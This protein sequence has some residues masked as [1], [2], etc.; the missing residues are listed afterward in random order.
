MTGTIRGGMYYVPQDIVDFGQE[1]ID[2]TIAYH[3]ALSTLV[4][5]HIDAR[6]NPYSKNWD[7][8]QSW[9]VGQRLW[10]IKNIEQ[11]A[12]DGHQTIGAILVAKVIELR[13]DTP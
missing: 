3:R 2:K 12:R 10:W 1:A 9:D 6:F 11:Q 5:E 4:I 13:L 7:V 8:W